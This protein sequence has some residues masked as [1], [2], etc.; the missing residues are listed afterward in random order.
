MSQF[1]QKRSRTQAA[2]DLYNIYNAVS[3]VPNELQED[4]KNFEPGVYVKNLQNIINAYTGGTCDSITESAHKCWTRHT[5]ADRHGT[6]Y[7]CTAYCFDNESKWLLPILTSFPKFCVLL[8]EEKEVT[9]ELGQNARYTMQF[10]QIEHKVIDSISIHVT[11]HSDFLFFEINIQSVRPRELKDQRDLFDTVEHSLN[12]LDHLKSNADRYV[13]E[14]GANRTETLTWG[15]S[16]PYGDEVHLFT[17]ITN[18]VHTI[19]APLLADSRGCDIEYIIH[20][21][22][23]AEPVFNPHSCTVLRKYLSSKTVYGVDSNVIVPE[24]PDSDARWQLDSE[25]RNVFRLSTQ[26]RFQKE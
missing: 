6:S 8:N 3:N 15:K 20:V 19:V 9:V 21:G 26:T 5:Y 22:R 12:N 25:A 14:N 11:P 2:S 23:F 13:D 7:N 16:F 4:E 18:L 10:T 1:K 24:F 17:M